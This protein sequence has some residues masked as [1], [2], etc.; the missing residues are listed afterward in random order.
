MKI[1]KTAR[2]I[3]TIGI[4][5][6]LLASSG[7][8]YTRQKAEQAQLS[9]DI[10]R[11]HQDFIKYATYI[12]QYA[13]QKKELEARLNVANSTIAAIQSEFLS[14]TESIEISDILFEAAAD[15]NVTIMELTSSL[16]EEEELDGITYQVFS[17][18]VTAEGEVVALLNFS[19]ELSQRFS[20]S[21]IQRVGINVPPEEEEEEEEE[22]QEEQEEQEEEEGEEEEEEE[23][24]E[25]EVE[26]PSIT[27]RLKIYA[28][29]RG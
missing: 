29:E 22:E 16:P 1:S 28:Y 14:P 9:S 27:L 15:T 25:E 8:T 6:I 7:V 3:L 19:K 12:T 10:A 13:A 11:A 21:D 24:E 18:E 26:K 17:I 4:L 23:Q 2:W 20:T 5:A